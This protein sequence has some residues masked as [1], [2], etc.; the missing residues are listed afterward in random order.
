LLAGGCELADLADVGGLGSLSAG[1]GV[2]LGVEDH[3]VD[4]LAGS[5][6]VVQAA[7]ADVVC[8]AVAAEDPD[9]LLGDVL[10]V[11]QDLSGLLAACGSGLL[12]LGDQGLGGSV[13]GAGVVLGLDELGVS[14][15]Q[16]LRSLVRADDLVD[17]ADQVLTDGLLAQ[18]QAQAVLGVVLEQGVDPGGTMAAVLVDGV[19][20]DG[21]GAAP[22]GGAAGGV[23]DVHLL[24]E[25]LGDQTCVRSLG[26]AGAGARE[27]QQGL[28]ELRAD[29]GVVRKL[30]GLLGDVG[31][32][33]VEHFLLGSL[34]LL[35]DHGDGLGGAD[36][37]ALAAAHAVQR[38][39]SHDELVL[40]GGLVVAVLGLLGSG[41]QHFRGQ[42]EGTDG[43]VRANEGALVA[44]H[45]LGGIPLGDGDGG[46]A[47]LI[48]GSALLPLAVGVV[49]EGGDRQ[50]V[51]VH[52]G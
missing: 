22:D 43:R 37:D 47:L 28:V 1:V 7:V 31:H 17:L 48:S 36:G 46:A 25:Q 23:G 18:I 6:D 8:P 27:L 3:D 29:D 34:A 19:G 5:Q 50:A 12:Q 2:H 38:R 44:A 9:R 51:A 26:A 24:T 52:A 13:V 20:R 45:A 42:Q 4:I 11:L 10:L 33:V 49:G 14:S 16:I 21:R 15:L 40:V 32:A 30:A 41:S 35:R 39:N